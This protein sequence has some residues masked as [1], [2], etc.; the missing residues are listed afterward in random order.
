MLGSGGGGRRN[1]VDYSS[2]CIYLVPLRYCVVVCLFFALDL[3][4]GRQK[5]AWLGFYIINCCN[6]TLITTPL[7]L[8]FAVSSLEY[9]LTSVCSVTEKKRKEWSLWRICCMTCFGL[10]L[11]VPIA[12]T[13]CFCSDCCGVGSALFTVGSSDL[14]WL[15]NQGRLSWSLNCSR[16]S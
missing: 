7:F 1:V 6:R 15:H 3:Q 16:W 9:C 8:F 14:S 13:A 2:I 10:E 4:Y 12:C 5:N 11:P